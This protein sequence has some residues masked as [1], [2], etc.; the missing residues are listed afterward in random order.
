MAAHWSSAG[1]A[2]CMLTSIVYSSRGQV[3]SA[4]VIGHLAPR[5]SLRDHCAV[6]AIFRKWGSKATKVVPAR[7]CDGHGYGLPEREGLRFH[8]QAALA[9][10]VDHASHAAHGLR[11]LCAFRDGGEARAREL[12]QHPRRISDSRAG[13]PHSLPAAPRSRSG[14]MLTRRRSLKSCLLRAARRP[15]GATAVHGVCNAKDGGMAVASAIGESG[16]TSFLRPTIR[17]L[18]SHMRFGASSQAT[19]PC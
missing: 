9:T 4:G 10:P 7:D 17:R 2:R 18:G 1:S 16:G 5:K 6:R 12:F 19:G 13:T 8:S 3:V 11:N 14:A 15:E